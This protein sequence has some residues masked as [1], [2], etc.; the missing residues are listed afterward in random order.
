M[1]VNDV[2]FSNEINQNFGTSDLPLAAVLSLYF[3]IESVNRSNPHRIEFEFENNPRL[4]NILQ[5]YLQSRLRVEPKQY[6]Y[7]LKTLKARIHGE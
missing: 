7:Q 5:E 2:V 3:P 1:D 6:F 4:Q